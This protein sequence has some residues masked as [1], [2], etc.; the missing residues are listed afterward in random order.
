M[1]SLA[2]SSSE[3][4]ARSGLTSFVGS[5]IN[6]GMGF[7]LTLVLARTMGDAG[8][9]VI[10]QA[11]GI[12]SI[13]L[14]VSRFGMDS[15]AIWIFPRL[16]VS[17]PAKARGAFVYQL[18]VSGSFG[19]VC[20]AALS[21]AIP[22]IRN[23]GD[24]NLVKVTDAL[25]PLV[26]FIPVASMML[27]CLSITRGLGGVRTFVLVG[28]IGLPVA[29]PLLVGI[30]AVSGGTIVAVSVAWAAPLL[31]ALMAALLVAW[32]QIRRLESA[33]HSTPVW[34]VSPDLRKKITL[35]ALPRTLSSVLEQGLLW[36]D[37]VL[38][39]AIA[40]SAAAGIYSG[41]SRFVAAGLII[42][43]ALRV[44][45]SPKF[46]ELIHTEQLQE[47]ETLYRLASRWLVLLSTPIYVMLAVFAP[48]ALSWLG[49]EFVEGS[50]A[51]GILAVGAI[52]TF[53]A[54]NI[55]SVLLMSGH[56][57]WA[58]INK[59]VVLVINVVG[60]LLLIP[61]WGIEG[62]AISWAA[63]MLIDAVLAA[64]EV[65]ILVGIHP[66]LNTVLQALLIGLLVFGLPALIFRT[67]LGLSLPSLLLSGTFSV[68]VF[69]L[70]GWFMRRRLGFRALLK[71]DKGNVR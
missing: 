42:D 5:L 50:R 44:V 27:V 33:A 4:L 57:G 52:L 8:S 39:G 16:R 70:L 14:S 41:A 23:A 59:I 53:L 11:I 40:G 24:P 35:Y 13:V 9:G 47:L 3:G 56:S 45:V 60:S 36:I 69:G 65:R 51:L 10:W 1:S 49:P 18:A 22:L 29:R 30:V 43:S 2:R 71:N 6:A 55:H 26:W 38:V 46:S 28:N 61:V 63:S 20:S 66:R 19:V 32:W 21:I 67:L 25:S 62:A 31:P 15:S 17:D 12:F 58:A 48:V 37:V 34:R 64:I 68:C 54:G 7:A